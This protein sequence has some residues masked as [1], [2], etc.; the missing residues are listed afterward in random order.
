MSFTTTV[1]FTFLVFLCKV[2]CARYNSLSTIKTDKIRVNQSKPCPLHLSDINCH[3]FTTKTTTHKELTAK[4][5]SQNSCLLVKI[6]SYFDESSVRIIVSKKYINSLTILNSCKGLYDGP[7]RKSV[8]YIDGDDNSLND[9]KINT[10]QFMAR[11]FGC[12]VVICSQICTS[13]ILQI[14]ETIGFGIGIYFWITIEPLPLKYELIYPKNVLHLTFTEKTLQDIDSGSITGIVKSALNA[15]LKDIFHKEE[16]LM[17]I[18]ISPKSGNYSFNYHYRS[19]VFNV[20]PRFAKKILM[21][22]VMVTS[23]ATQSRPDLLDHID[24]QC[25][26]GILC[27]VHPFRNGSFGDAREPSCCLG[28]FMDILLELKNDLPIDFYVYE[29]DDRQWGF[30]VNGSWNGLIG[31]VASGSADIA[32]DWSVVTEAAQS[33]VDFTDA[34]LVDELV[35]ASI[36][37]VSPLPYLNLEV[38]RSLTYSSWITVLSVTLV[39][40]GIIYWAERLFELRSNMESGYGILTYALG[41]LF[42]R[43]AGGLLPKNLGSQVI[44]ITLALSLMIIMTTYTAVL[45][46]RNIEDRKMFS[47]SGMDDPKMIH[48]SPNFK[49]GTF[50]DFNYFERHSKKE[51]R[52]LGEFMKTYKFSY[53]VDAYDRMRKGFLDAVI[54]EKS[55][56]QLN[57]KHELY[58]DVKIVESVYEISIAFALRK[59]SHWN[60]PISRL[61]GKYKSRGLLDNLKRRY[62]VSHCIKEDTNQPKQFGILYLSGACI[63]LILGFIL[64]IVSFLFEK[65]I[66]A[67]ANHRSSYTLPHHVK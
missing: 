24:M 18:M 47:I 23:D 28:F 35:L 44:S 25:L 7:I 56:L 46:T 63:L 14:A 55:A 42:Q 11:D 61:I 17:E 34:Y 51:L 45:T 66:N 2:D 36:V 40:S 3:S 1:Y 6:A 54:I 16:V 65:L 12:Y 9:I 5:I 58:C 39:T 38:F 41:L 33:V 50:T 20:S 15:K 62:M 43:D 29:V 37:Q 57:W 49:I 19:N 64:S 52:R 59:G 8:V 31:E 53:F 22:A 60:E 32:A 26:H 13:L 48:L 67:C 27:W 4:T 10:M 21:K 30:K